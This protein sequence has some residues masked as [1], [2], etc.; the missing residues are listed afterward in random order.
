MLKNPCVIASQA[1][2]REFEPRFSLI[3]YQPLRCKS[4]WLFCFSITR[5]ITQAQLALIFEPCNCCLPSLLTSK[6]LGWLVIK[7]TVA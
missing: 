1:E 6:R 5:W 7:I 2:G 4:E 3:D